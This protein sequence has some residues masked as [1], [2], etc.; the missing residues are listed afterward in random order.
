MRSKR[1]FLKW[2]IFACVLCGAPSGLLHAQEIRDLQTVPWHGQQKTRFRFN[3]VDAYY[4]QPAHPLP[5]K[6]WIW[7]AHFPDWHTAMDSLLLARGFSVAYINTNDQY[8]APQAMMTWD[9]F[10]RYMTGHLGFAPRVAL[11]GVSRG[12]LYVYGWAKRNP[13]KVSCIYAEA[14]VC[15][16]K[17]WP[18]GKGQGM[19]DAHNWEQL[20]KVY[21][22]SE[23]QALAY[24][25]NPV[26][27][28]EGL[29]AFKIPV[30]HVIGLEDH[31]VPPAENTFV[32]VD[33]YLKLG[34]PA[35]VY[36]ETRGPQALHGHHFT[37][38]DPSLG[39]DFVY[40]ASYPVIHPLAYSRYYQVR[41]GLP[42]FF[43]AVR[44]GRPVTVAFLGGSITYNP[45]WR[46][47]LSRYLQERFPSVR[48]RFLAA[49]IP[50]LGSVPHAFRLQRDV[51][52]SGSVDLLFVEAA[53]ND[54][55]NGTDS[56][57]QVRAL[58]GIVRHA[59]KANPRMDIALF[60]FA[61]PDK[62]AIYSRGTTPTA[63]ANHEQVASHYHLPSINLAREVFE[64]IRAGEFSW[65]YDFKN[66]HPAPFGQELYFET[67]KDLLNACGEQ[68][69]GGRS[70][71]GTLPLPPPLN[72]YNF[73]GGRYVDVSAARDL[74]HFRR[75]ADW[76]P[77]DKAHTRKG[78]VHVPLLEA[79]QP[80]AALVLSFRGTAVGL[81][82][83]AGPDAGEIAYRIDGG[84]EKTMD[85]FTRWSSSLYLPWYVMLGETLKNTKH[86]LH[87]RVLPAKNAGS[88]G[89]ACRIVHFLVNGPQVAAH[90]PEERSET[91]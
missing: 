75:I 26:D 60:S 73:S 24:E 67:M 15:D 33:R 83:L 31:V 71:T 29:A 42:H 44:S 7:R 36:P 11:E 55:G 61:D 4:I 5:G 62:L 87:L 58:E 12:G 34:G 65:Q 88:K 19:G 10:Y 57:S 91:P 22:M 37:I 80:G 3:G 46:D 20:L 9:L 51:L 84:P 30:F 82:V 49:G 85:L 81:S 27:H 76:T 8:G 53:V 35:L 59:R 78:F 63:V 86:V 56:T 66:L 39:A 90:H 40:R 48:F 16:I 25:D 50:S 69:A 21:G 28:L 54:S 79:T 38:E 45:G 64:K 17:S 70:D 43:Q 1:I 14:P 41:G 6:P 47:M 18:G 32:L 2:G 72:K 23:A 89:T 77:A 13:D 68:D 74:Q 52:D